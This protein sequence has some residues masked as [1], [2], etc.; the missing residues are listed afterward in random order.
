MNLLDIYTQDIIYK[1]LYHSI[2]DDVM[3]ELKWKCDFYT[4]IALEYDDSCLTR[5]LYQFYKIPS[6]YRYQYMIKTT[7]NRLIKP[8]DCEV[9]EGFTK[10]GNRG[11]DDALVLIKYKGI[12]KN[13]K[14]F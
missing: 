7:L 13:I 1:V 9:N 6:I 2:F 8:V 14:L 5:N 12:Q 4:S 11:L 3:N 10:Y